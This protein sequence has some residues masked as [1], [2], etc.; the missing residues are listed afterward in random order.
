MNKQFKTALKL[1]VFA[2]MAVNSIHSQAWAVEPA[3]FMERV[4]NSLK[5]NSWILSSSKSEAD[6][7]DI[8]L[9]EAT[10]KPNLPQAKSPAEPIKIGDLRFENVTED[11]EGNYKAATLKIPSFVMD[12]EDAKLQIQN[13][14]WDNLSFI[15]DKNTNPMLKFLPYEKLLVG[16]ISVSKSTTPFLSID[17]LKVIYT[18]KDGTQT[19]D[20]T[21]GIDAF[22]FQPEQTGDPAT[23]SKFKNLGYEQLKG[24]FDGHMLWDLKSGKID[25]DKA[26]LKVDDA[27]NLN[28]TLN[29]E[30]VTAGLLEDI[31]TLRNSALSDKADQNVVMLGLMGVSQ[32][33]SL[34]ELQIRYEDK[35]LTG[36]ALDLGASQNGI[37]RPD[38]VAQIKTMLPLMGTQINHPA[39]VKN[40]SEQLS[41]FLDN[42]QSLTI[43]AKPTK[44]IS[45]AILGATAAT[46]KEQLIDMLDIKV[47]AN[48]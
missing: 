46:A 15:S 44:P 23:V 48:K 2:F 29:L 1:S 33:I 18:P 16:S 45:F 27:G 22:D 34:G 3:A 19:V 10:L 11:N 20:I 5:A 36:R 14:E 47:E 24:S 9:R 42:P 30:G 8:I 39:F 28:I 32:Q 26:E 43:S 40:T 35:S 17:G 38:F 31:A 41:T 6:G 37:S 7:D 4:Q 21:S 12:K 13:M 25:S